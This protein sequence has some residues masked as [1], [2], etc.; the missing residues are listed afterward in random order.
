MAKKNNEMIN[1]TFCKSFT[2][3]ELIIVVIIV[4]ILA[5]LAIPRFQRNIERARMAEAISTLKS[6]RDAQMRYAMATDAYTATSSDLDIG[7]VP[8]KYFTFTVRNPS[9]VPSPTNT[10]ENEWLS[11][12]VRVSS[13]PSVFGIYTIAINETGAIW[14]PSGSVSWWLDY[15][16]PSTPIN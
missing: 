5:R 7:A 1:K 4:G 15:G 10:D 9:P 12:A 2:L 11:Y 14:S 8:G 13:P 6:V 3:I 16:T